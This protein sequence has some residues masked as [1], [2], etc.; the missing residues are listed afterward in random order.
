MKTSTEHLAAHTLRNGLAIGTW[1]N[2]NSH[3]PSHKHN[4]NQ[5]HSRRR[6]HCH[7]HRQSVG[8]NNQAKDSIRKCRGSTKLD[9]VRGIA[10]PLLRVCI[11]GKGGVRMWRHS[12]PHT[13]T[14]TQKPTHAHTPTHT[15]TQKKTSKRTQMQ[16]IDLSY[17]GPQGGNARDANIP[18][19]HPM[20]LI[21]F[22]TFGQEIRPLRMH[23]LLV[24][25]SDHRIMQRAHNDSMHIITPSNRLTSQPKQPT[26]SICNF[27]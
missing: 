23:L 5:S 18:T 9:V 10:W 12:N 15:H 8:N 13:H 20:P 17:M 26:T 19:L 25:T 7:N 16:T 24:R 14:H 6:E 22:Y 2:H 11:R 4:H 21:G 1:G 27:A 3:D